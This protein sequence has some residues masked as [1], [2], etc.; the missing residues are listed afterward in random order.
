MYNFKKNAKLYI[1]EGSN[2]H[3]IEVYSDISASQTFDEQSYPQKTLHNQVA[4]HDGAVITKANTANFSFTT[5]IHNVASG[6]TPIVLIL[7]GDYASGSLASFD[8][9]IESDNVI[10]RLQSA[11]IEGLTFNIER[12]AILT[13]TVS[14]TASRLSIHSTSA[15]PVAVPGTPVSVGSR[16]YVYVAGLNTSISGTA[17][18]SVAALNVEIRYNVSWSG[19]TTLQASL[20]N[21]ISYPNGYVVSGREIIGSIT[22]FITT[23]NVSLLSDTSTS[24]P[25][26]ID[27]FDSVGATTPLL[28]FNLPSVVY[29]R[30]LNMEEIFNRVYDF[31]LNNNSTIVKPIYKGV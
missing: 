14:G 26:V 5:P 7:G 29:T 20:N 12:G 2:R 30:R 1:V 9:Y 28:K 17:L 8:I 4:L 18:T 3:S 11:V 22:Q 15:A 24:A 31:R 16:S 27:I 23:D 21:T 13:V 19:Y 10:Y 25:V 6:T